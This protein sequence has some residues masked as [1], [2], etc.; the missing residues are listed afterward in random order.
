[1]ETQT[2][3]KQSLEQEF[4]EQLEAFCKDTS[5]FKEYERYTPLGP[6]VLLKL[7]KFVPKE[8]TPELG[9]IPILTQSP[10]DGSWKWGS[11]AM[12]EKVYNIAMVIKIGKGGWGASA[13]QPDDVEIGQTYVV[14]YN[15]VVGVDVNPKFLSVVNTF[16]GPVGSQGALTNIPAEIPQ[17]LPNL[18]IH[19]SRFKFSMPDRLGN[20]TDDDKLIYLVNAQK[21]E[22]IY[23]FK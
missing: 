9:H 11:D 19:W 18:D 14:P 10:L 5:Y 2:T 21:L 22:A 4:K 6:K 15:D 3:T 13:V 23:K 7:F 8:K 12:A 20:E 16:K 17:N 1:M